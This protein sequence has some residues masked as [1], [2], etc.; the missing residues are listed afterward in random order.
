MKWETPLATQ[1]NITPDNT[2]IHVIYKDQLSSLIEFIKGILWVDL[3]ILCFIYSEI[4]YLR[5][6]KLISWIF[7]VYIAY[8]FIDI[9]CI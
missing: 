2:V 3:F 1:T 5:Y 7:C 4:H 8:L 9:L 6:I